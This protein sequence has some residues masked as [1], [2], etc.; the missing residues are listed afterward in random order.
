LNLAVLA[1]LFATGFAGMIVE[2]AMVESMLG[3]QGALLR[4]GELPALS[5]IAV[6][7]VSV[8]AVFLV[9]FPFTA[10]THAYMK[11]F[12]YHS[13]RWDDAPAATDPATQRSVAESLGRA[14]SWAAPHI[15]GDGKKTWR[16]VVSAESS[17]IE[18]KPQP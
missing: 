13:V 9:Y 16:E 3:V 14:V 17:R 4:L 6:A 5:G 1:A 2:P 7:H 11:F 18:T 8:L 10:M 15:G 12:T